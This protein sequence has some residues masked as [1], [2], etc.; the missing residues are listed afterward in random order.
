MAKQVS[1]EL[2]SSM[3]EANAASPDRMEQLKKMALEVIQ[4]ENS[5]ADLTEVLSAQK[6]AVRFI[7]DNALTEIMLELGIDNFEMEDGSKLK[8][9]NY[10]AGSLPKGKEE[11]ETAVEYLSTEGGE[12]LIKTLIS[13]EFEK[14]QHNEALDL[15]ETIRQLGHD[16]EIESTVNHMTL[17]AFGREKLA[18]GEAFDMEKVGLSSGRVVKVKIPKKK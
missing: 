7:K 18:N 14:T 13:V 6:K 2:A 1:D 11:R 3:G 10:V 5:I 16:P 17:A 15:L 8:L 9:H 12:A 4:Y